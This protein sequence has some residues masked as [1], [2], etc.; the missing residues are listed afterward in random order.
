LVFFEVAD[1]FN[2]AKVITQS[3]F[4]GIP[5]Y[6]EGVVYPSEGGYW[7]STRS[8]NVILNTTCSEKSELGDYTFDLLIRAAIKDPTTGQPIPGDLGVG[9]V[10]GQ[11]TDTNGV[12]IANAIVT[13]QQHSYT[14]STPCS[15]SFTTAAE[16]LYFFDTV[17]FHDTDTITLMV[18]ANGFESR[19]IS[20]SAFITNDWVANIMLNKLP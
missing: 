17:H 10:H 15:G 2:S 11:V 14:N 3:E 12:P 16:G 6:N 9:S 18:Q 1:D 7:M 4:S 19:E 5:Q 13:C 20:R 8:Y